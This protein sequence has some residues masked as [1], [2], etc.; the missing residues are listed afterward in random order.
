MLHNCAYPFSRCQCS[1]SA[2]WL[3]LC[4]TF[5]FVFI[6]PINKKPLNPV[7]W[8]ITYAFSR[9]SKY[10]TFL[11]KDLNY[12]IPVLGFLPNKTKIDLQLHNKQELLIANFVDYLTKKEYH[13]KMCFDGTFS[14]LFILFLI[15]QDYFFALVHLNFAYVLKD[16]FPLFNFPFTKC[17]FFLSILNKNVVIFKICN[18][19]S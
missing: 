10:L 17:I 8:N 19:F 18:L 14:S 2:F 13:F 12:A 11:L 5:I 6:N 3:W 4:G 16:K 9:L 1:L 15:T 7:I